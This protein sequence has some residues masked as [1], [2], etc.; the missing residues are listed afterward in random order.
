[1]VSWAGFIAAQEAHQ[2]D[3]LKWIHE[4]PGGYVHPDQEFRVDPATGLP[5]M[6]ATKFIPEGTVLCQVPWKI[7]ITSDTPDDED[8]NLSCGTSYST[9]TATS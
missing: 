9:R 8:Q 1:M 6:F 3:V 4:T 2:H 7:T 5:G